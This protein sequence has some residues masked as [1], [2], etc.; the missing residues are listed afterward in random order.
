MQAKKKKPTA[1]G[2]QY[3][4]GKQTN[5]RRRTEVG[6]LA[7]DCFVGNEW[8]VATGSKKNSDK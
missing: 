1:V 6:L 8:P 7:A 2:V 3:R 4:F 5:G